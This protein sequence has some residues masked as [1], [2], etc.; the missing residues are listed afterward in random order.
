MREI[1]EMLKIPKST[2]D[3]H[4]QRLGLVKK[5]WYLD[6]TWIRRNSFNKTHQCLIC[7]LNELSLVI[8]NWLFRIM[9]FKNDDGQSVINHHKQHRKLNC[10]KKDYAVCLMGLERCGIFLSCLQETKRLIQMSTVVSWTNWTQRS[11]KNGQNWSII[12]V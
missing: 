7:I 11:M 10:I 2:M 4:I 12:K 5:T 1:K 8:K 9:S 3:R 6:S